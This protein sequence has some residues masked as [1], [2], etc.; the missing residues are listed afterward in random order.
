MNRA[1]ARV[2]AEVGGGDI[3]MHSSI[4]CDEL[5]RHSAVTQLFSSKL[6]QLLARQPSSVHEI[7]WQEYRMVAISISGDLLVK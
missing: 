6:V 4:G 1:Q 2:Y 5:K 7:S 3:V